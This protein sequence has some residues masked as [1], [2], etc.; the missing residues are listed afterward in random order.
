MVCGIDNA[1]YAFMLLDHC[2]AVTCL[3]PCEVINSEQNEETRLIGV[4]RTGNVV[5]V[6]L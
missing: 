4:K 1:D 3:T 5:L 2:Y 6:S